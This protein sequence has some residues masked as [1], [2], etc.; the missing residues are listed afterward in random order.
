MPNSPHKELFFR[1]ALFALV[2][3]S[4]TACATI[5]PVE[6]VLAPQIVITGINGE[7]RDNLL[8]IL[9]PPSPLADTPRKTPRQLQQ[10]A[11][12]APD[13]VRQAL[14]PFGYY[15]PGVKSRVAEE[16]LYLTVDTGPPVRVARLTISTTPGSSPLIQQVLHPF[17]LAEGDVLRHQAYEDGKAQLLTRAQ[18]LGFLDARFVTHTVRVDTTQ[19]S[20]EIDLALD[21]GPRYRN[22]ELQFTGAE[23]YPDSFLQRYLTLRPGEPLTYAELGTSQ[24]QLRDSG[25][26]SRVILTP[27]FAEA[28]ADHEVPIT[29]ELTP[30]ARR[31]LRPGIGYGTDTGGRVSLRY[32]DLN[33]FERGHEFLADGLLAERKRSLTGQYLLP[34][35]HIKTTTAL[36]AGFEG[37]YL[38][39]YETRFVYTE[40]EQI[41]GL[42]N[43]RIASVYA[44]FQR[45]DSDIGGDSI[46]SRYLLAGLRYRQ[47]RVDNPTRPRQGYSLTCELRGT[48]KS[49]LSDVSLMQVLMGVRVLA[50]LGGPLFL[51]MRAN[52]AATL[53][54]N[55]FDEVP[56]SLR[57]FTGG[58]RTVRG[59]AYQ[60][61]GPLDAEGDVVGGKNLLDGSLELEWRFFDHWGSA[62]FYDAG[63][64]FNSFANMKLAEAAG[65]GIRY[66]TIVGPVW[67]DLARSVNVPDPAYRVHFGIGLSW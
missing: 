33:A 26:F 14:E 20:A 18:D 43:Q 29:V 62:I 11:N 50:P 34:G 58:D 24:Q 10:L 48:E 21:S 52:G 13:K 7:L 32:S 31:Q 28:T 35:A 61:L 12:Q 39:S 15:S 59:Y 3:L 54:E 5:T 41:W 63:N 19:R 56:A 9:A 67:F 23:S 46:T 57:F 22:G 53:Q 27:R 55:E 64:A 1:N 45:E 65:G 60:S 51:H 8:A 16:R 30:E 49:L 25:H 42:G 47:G 4:T 36:R 37:E 44:R 40:G 66:Y 2:L 6:N 38:D 17:P